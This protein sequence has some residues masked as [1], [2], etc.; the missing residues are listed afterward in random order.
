MNAEGYQIKTAGFEGPLELLLFLIEK[1]KLFVNEISL[2]QVTDDYVAHVKKLENFPVAHT[3]NFILVAATLLLIKSRSLLPGLELSSEETESIEMLER[4][5]ALYKLFRKRA[6]STEELLKGPRLFER[7]YRGHAPV[8]SPDKSFTVENIFA[9]MKEVISHLP[10]K[11]VLP[12]VLVEKVTS[13]EE[14]ISRIT[15][16]VKNGLE[17]NFYSLLGV[18][19]KVLSR[20]DKF[21]VIVG[22]LALLELVKQG[23]LSAAQNRDSEE[24]EIKT[25]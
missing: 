19:K 14:M 12:D 3:A 2:S 20:K 22:F 21:E 25:V 11:V 24:I 17:T 5:L 15:E 16:R 6:Q 8:F 23:L 1:R 18:G 4:R 9:A 10:R 13:L 7:P